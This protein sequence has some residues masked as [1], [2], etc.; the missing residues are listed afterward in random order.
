[1]REGLV[2]VIALTDIE[3]QTVSMRRYFLPSHVTWLT[4]IR[5]YGE[6]WQMWFGMPVH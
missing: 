2:L 5:G 4:V 1:M 3:K 6:G